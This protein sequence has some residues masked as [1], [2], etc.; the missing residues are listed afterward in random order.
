[1]ERVQLVLTGLDESVARLRHFVP[2]AR[3]IAE[4]LGNDQPRLLV[5][6]GEALVVGVEL[7]ERLGSFEGDLA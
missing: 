5:E 4:W 6:E 2:D 3:Q 7:L 1:M